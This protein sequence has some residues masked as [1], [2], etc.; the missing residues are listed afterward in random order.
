MQ[1]LEAQFSE[2]KDNIRNASWKNLVIKIT[3][4]PKTKG[5]I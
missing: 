4:A 2:K 3:S 1:V 5:I